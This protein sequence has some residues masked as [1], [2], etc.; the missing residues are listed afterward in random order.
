MS[1]PL[2]TEFL[3]TVSFHLLPFLHH[4]FLKHAEGLIKE[5]LL[6]KCGTFNVPKQISHGFPK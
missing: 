3:T 6:W 1:L 4:Y 2:A 5:V